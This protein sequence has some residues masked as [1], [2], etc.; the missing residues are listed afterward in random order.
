VDEF[1]ARQQLVSFSLRIACPLLD[2]AEVLVERG[3]EAREA[4]ASM[5][6]ANSPWRTIMPPR[7]VDHHLHKL[8]VVLDVLLEAPFLIL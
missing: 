4:A 1:R 2:E 7:R 3:H 8:D 5:R 6:L